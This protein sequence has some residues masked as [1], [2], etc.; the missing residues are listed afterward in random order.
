LFNNLIGVAANAASLGLGPAGTRQIAEA[1]GEGDAAS[2]AATRRT[3]FWAT[4]FLA[5]AGALI[6]WLLRKVL[7]N[8]LLN[9]ASLADEV[10]WLALGVALT[11]AA[12]SQ[13]SLLNGLRR[14]SDLAWVTVIS[15]I[16]AS[17]L[18]IPVLLIWEE[19]GILA[20]L[21]LVP[22]ATFIVGWFYTARVPRIRPGFTPLKV[23]F[24]QS[25]AMAKLGMAFMLG[26]LA[27]TLANLLVRTLVQRS[28]GVSALGHFEAAWLISMTYVGLVLRAMGAD[29]F[30]RLTAVIKSPVVANKL[31]NQQTEVVLL[32]AG[33]MVLMLIGLSPWV[34]QA[35]YSI[36]FMESVEIL[37]WQILGDILKF[38]SWPL[39]VVII[40]AG[41]G[42]TYLLA[43]IFA[44]TI[45]VLAVWVGLPHFG[46]SIT[47]IGFMAMY[48]L[49]LPVVYMLAR[50][51]TGFRWAPI[52]CVNFWL[53]MVLG[54]LEAVVAHSD[55]VIGGVFSVCAGALYSLYA[56]RRLSHMA[57][58]SG[59]LSRL[60]RFYSRAARK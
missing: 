55:A 28:L 58:L 60:T 19:R 56:I 46:L 42:K 40:A 33:P 39:G 1:A 36:E 32:L 51:R 21:L 12:I 23:I 7:A 31:V 44:V 15:A 11:V 41:D 35:M 52:V 47:G 2:I 25:Q 5:F 50:K 8:H 22:L 9:D 10:G 16:L 45:L 49:Y 53:L 26:G 54:I 24:K 20:Y 57:D 18:G 34:V 4:S 48:A 17:A 6:F 38:A 30:P 43:E 13:S 37:R 29:F 59:P 14:I 3:L 27:V